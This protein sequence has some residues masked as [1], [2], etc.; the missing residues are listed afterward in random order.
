MRVPA[1]VAI[2]KLDNASTRR[3]AALA[4]A[5]YQTALLDLKRQI[6]LPAEGDSR[7]DAIWQKVVVRI[8]AGT[9]F[10]GPHR[11]DVAAALSFAEVEG[12]SAG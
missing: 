5:N 8:D 3:Q 6:G 2:I 10:A 11:I 12:E 7:W 1:D 9:G 4:G